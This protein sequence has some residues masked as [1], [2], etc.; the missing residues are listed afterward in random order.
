VSWD[1]LWRR[2][3]ARLRDAVLEAQSHQ[4]KLRALEQFLLARLTARPNA[5]VQYALTQFQRAS[6][7][8]SIA[9]IVEHTGLSSRRFIASFRDEVGLT[10]KLFTRVCRFQRALAALQGRN[11]VDWADTAIACGYF[12][13]AHMIHDFREFAGVSPA[14]YLRNRTGAINHVR[15]VD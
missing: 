12:D 10:P 11:Q 7:A 6:R 13:Q 14:V 15:C 2:D 5:A 9:A 1:D 4:A 3:A 8:A